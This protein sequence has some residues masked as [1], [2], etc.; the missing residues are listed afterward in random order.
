MNRLLFALNCMIVSLMAGMGCGSSDA[1]SPA[2]SSSSAAPTSSSSVSSAGGYIADHMIAKDSVLRSIPI[3]Y[4]DLARKNSRI[5]YQHTSHGTHVSKGLFGLPGFKSGDS[6]LFGITNNALTRDA[7]KLDF[8]DNAIVNPSDLSTADSD[9]DAWLT[10]N[11]TYLD[12]HPEIN[13]LL[14]SWC[15]ISNHN[16]AKYLSSATTIIGEYGAGGSKGRTNPVTFI[17]MTGHAN[18]ANN[19]GSGKPKAQAKLITDYCTANG[20]FC[21]D[22]YAIDTHDMADIY[23]EAAGDNGNYSGGNY[24]ESWQTL[25][26]LGVD[27]YYNLSSPGGSIEYGDH[28]TQHITANRKAFA[29]WWV[30]ARIAGWDGIS[31]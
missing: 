19:T 21:I 16:V 28:N 30:F 11:R 4:I 2:A 25:H 18:L 7:D 26:A 9:W 3:A 24:Y 20:Y 10:A 17:F 27:W 23:Y 12:A 29:A 31:R 15:D 5:A 1:S 8:H 22:Y 13:I 6:A 14:W